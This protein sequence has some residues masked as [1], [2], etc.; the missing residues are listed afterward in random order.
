M[1]QPDRMKQKTRA[2]G[3][4][5]VVWTLRS[6]DARIQRRFRDMQFAAR[7]RHIAENER[8]PLGILHVENLVQASLQPSIS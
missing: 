7:I 2:E 5:L 4:G 8:R 6:M 3:V 1:A